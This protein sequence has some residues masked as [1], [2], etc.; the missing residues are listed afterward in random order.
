VLIAAGA[1]AWSG[2]GTIEA[3]EWLPYAILVALALAVAAATGVLVRPARAVLPAVAALVGLAAWAAISI[4]WTPVPSLARDEALLTLLYAL[5]LAI[6][7]LTLVTRLDR[8]VA[9]ALVV[10]ALGALA[11]A[12]FV[13][14]RVTASP[15][16]L[17]FGGRLNFPVTYVNGDAAF[18]LVGFWPAIA[19][20]AVRRAPFAARALSLTAATALLAAGVATQSKGSALG[21]AVSAIAIFAAAPRRLRLLV[22]TLLA[23]VL[24]A[25]VFRPLTEPYRATGTAGASAIRHSA[26]IALVV[27]AVAA[28]LGIAYALADRR[29]AVPARVTRAAGAAVLAGLVLAL[30]GGLA[31]FLAS[32]DRPGH[33]LAEKWNAF[34]H[35]AGSDAGTTHLLSFGSNRYDFWRVAAHEFERHPLAGGGSRSF[36]AVYLRHRASSETPA[37]AH[38]LPLD[39]LSETGVVGFALLVA[40]LGIPLSVLLRRRSHVAL[41]AFGAATYWLTHSLVDWIW[42]IPA[43]GLPF[44]L[45]LGIGCAGRDDGV[46]AEERPLRRGPELAI[47]ACAGLA[48]ALLFAPPWLSSRL[49][50]QAKGDPRGAATDLRWARRLDPL[51]LDPYFAAFQLSSD[52]LQRVAIAA[53]AVRKAPDWMP[54]QY[55]LGVAQLEAGRRALARRHLARA[56]Q[57]DPREPRLRAALRRAEH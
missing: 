33:Y 14:A 11:V 2:L 13:K 30:A 44:F 50:A 28:V 35:P 4:A 26:T 49:V 9:L 18:F 6:P 12:T 54:T 31:A 23:L 41:A 43:V 42:T 8:V 56:L 15:L 53:E 39:V 24:V 3:R 48:A 36:I 27:T 19:L 32:V 38:S 20:S 17:Y 1:L 5:A 46:E 40:A 21:L 51:S 47:A 55:L 34:E 25:P 37:R 57:L 7:L 22:P 29:I 10:G 52:P 16:D 45:L